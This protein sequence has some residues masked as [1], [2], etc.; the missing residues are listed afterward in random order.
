MNALQPSCDLAAA[1]PRPAA[2]MMSAW[3]A[4]SGASMRLVASALVRV[5]ADYGDR[6]SAWIGQH[7]VHPEIAARKPQ[8]L[9]LSLSTKLIFAGRPAP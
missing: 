5:A 7:A 8:I 3:R 9:P 4:A 2:V 1:L 6:A